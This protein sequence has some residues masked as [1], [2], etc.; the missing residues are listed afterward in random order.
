MELSRFVKWG[1]SNVTYDTSR[2]SG[3]CTNADDIFGAYI[4][5]CHLVIRMQTTT[6]KCSVDHRVVSTESLPVEFV[7]T[8]TKL[9][10]SLYVMIRFTLNVGFVAVLPCRSIA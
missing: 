6:S 5:S 1:L 2:H 8:S 3:E 7:Q 4:L 9:T 10:G